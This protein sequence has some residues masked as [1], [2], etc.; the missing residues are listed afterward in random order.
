MVVSPPAMVIKAIFGQLRSDIYTRVRAGGR[1]SRRPVAV[2]C[3]S[4][5]TPGSIA[6]AVG[7]ERA[8]NLDI[9]RRPA[10]EVRVLPALMVLAHRDPM[11]RRE[12]TSNTLSRNSLPSPVGISVPS[13]YHLRFRLCAPNERLTRS[14][15]RQ[16]P[17]GVPELRSK[18]VTSGLGCG[19]VLVDQPAEDWSA[20]DPAQDWLGDRRFRAGRA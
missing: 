17:C 1:Q 13:P 20:P 10:L 11:M 9:D 14:G 12:A 18:H 7:L 8:R 16:R 4:L 2:T 15:A 5:D 3:G 19:F 6:V